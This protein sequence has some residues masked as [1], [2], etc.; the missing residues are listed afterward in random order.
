[1]RRRKSLLTVFLI[2]L[3]VTTFGV[4]S[5]ATS[6]GRGT[7]P[8]ARKPQG[9][10]APA[11]KPTKFKPACV[12]PTYPSPPPAQ[13]AQID[14]L[15]GLSGAGVG[16]EGQQDMVKNNFCAKGTPKPITVA[17]LTS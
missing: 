7:T 15:C 4:T 17:D 13:A 3:S 9:R 14:S 1:M 5:L 11:F 10:A 2:L 16:S 6:G 8:P 12:N